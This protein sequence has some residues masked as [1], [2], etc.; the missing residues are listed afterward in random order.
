MYK[1]HQPRISRF[2]L[3]SADNMAKVM[4]MVSLSIQQPW[5]AVG[6]QLQDVMTEGRKSRFLWGSKGKLFDYVQKHKA[7]LFVSL[8]DYKKKRITLAEL[9]VRFA[10][11]DGLGLVKA[12]FVLQLCL[13]KVGCLDIHNLRMYGVNPSDFK[14]GKN[15]TLETKLRKAELYI[16]MCEK[17][18]GSEK[19]W[20]TWCDN[21]AQNPRCRKYFTSKHH[22]SRVHCE[23]IGA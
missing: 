4:T 9:L 19:L 5:Y 11:V 6:K 22:V 23:F 14:Y 21:L 8:H 1:T 12:G 18:G 13:G 17:L 16:A 7:D 15:A 3:Q 20:D 2:A 10:E